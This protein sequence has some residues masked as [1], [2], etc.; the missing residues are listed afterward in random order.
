MRFMNALTGPTV[1]TA[2][3]VD[4]MMSGRND[5]WPAPGNGLF[6]LR[7]RERIGEGFVAGVTTAAA[8]WLCGA[9]VLNSRSIR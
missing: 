4:T 9:S 1:A 6:L 2:G 7:L 3:Q 8:R 5:R